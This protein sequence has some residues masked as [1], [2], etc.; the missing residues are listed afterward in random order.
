MQKN[1]YEWCLQMA[2]A[3]M[4]DLMSDLNDER[5]KAS[6]LT[7]E[8]VKCQKEL[9]VLN[10]QFIAAR[11]ESS[12]LR[13]ECKADCTENQDLLAERDRLL[14]DRDAA[15]AIAAARLAELDEL[16]GRIELC[17][18][19]DSIQSELNTL[20]NQLTEFQKLGSAGWFKLSEIL[21]GLTES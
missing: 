16:R 3:D 14:R 19:R 7:S 12:E 5:G 2:H 4:E 8:L 9:A 15:R 20:R 10:E 17:S 11:V 13:N 1:V 6:Y 21:R 18:T